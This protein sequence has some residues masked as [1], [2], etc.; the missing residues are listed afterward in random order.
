[1]TDRSQQY[2][3]I[4]NSFSLPFATSPLY[5]CGRPQAPP[6]PNHKQRATHPLHSLS[7]IPF[8][9]TTPRASAP[10]HFGGSPLGQRTYYPTPFNEGRDGSPTSMAL[11]R[12]ILR[13]GFFP[14][15]SVDNRVNDTRPLTLLRLQSR[16]IRGVNDTCLW[17]DR[18]LVKYD[19]VIGTAGATT[20]SSSRYSFSNGILNS[21]NSMGF[22]P[23]TAEGP[24]PLPA[25]IN[26]ADLT[27]IT[28]TQVQHQ[29]PTGVE[30]EAVELEG[31]S[32][33]ITTPPIYA[34]MNW[35]VPYVH[36][37]QCLQYLFS[38]SRRR[39]F[40]GNHLLS[41]DTI[42]PTS[43]LQCWANSVVTSLRENRERD[44]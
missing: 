17:R 29:M 28:S 8:S 16:L 13:D 33:R 20:G 36:R 15:H 42:S 18:L 11:E 9:L 7:P 38:E 5:I 44:G 25:T 4:A 27:Q 10:I 32:C 21:R 30:E 31:S 37:Y 26:P 34:P 12:Y 43:W 35:N 3:L 14:D 39:L 23:Q 19:G 2:N 41:R 1:M 40:T 6:R 24:P 22:G